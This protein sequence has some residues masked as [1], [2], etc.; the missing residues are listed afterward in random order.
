MNLRAVA[1]LT[2]AIGRGLGIGHL[3]RCRTIGEWLESR[4]WEVHSS[5]LRIEGEDLSLEGI[6]LPK[7]EPWGSVRGLW[8]IDASIMTSSLVG[9][10]LRDVYR[11]GGA[12]WRVCIIDNGT[13]SALAP[14]VS[15]AID[16]SLVVIPHGEC[17]RRSQER[18]R[19]GIGF[20]VLPM[21]LFDSAELRAL[22]V[23]MVAARLLVTAGGVDS[24]E[25]S[26]FYV[27][28]LEQINNECLHVTLIIGRDFSKKHIESLEARTQ[29]SRHAWTLVRD[30]PSIV[31]FAAETD[32]ALVA[33]GLTK[34]EMCAMGI[35][36]VIV[37][38]TEDHAGDSDLLSELGAALR[39]GLLADLDPSEC[40]KS[41][42]CLLVDSARRQAMV[43]IGRGA[44][45]RRFVEMTIAE[46]EEA[47]L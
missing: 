24:A 6:G 25:I 17:G 41:I 47:A 11:G 40:A 33:G 43:D 28:C 18:F 39:L 38:E 46:I 34:I 13:S 45:N 20:A 44:V 2:P 36:S 1:V 30:V 10:Y 31:P 22:D 9:T 27:D 16:P 7:L 19:I 5:P 15:P 42:A 4:G 26:S 12:G 32:L 8:L 37:D 35:P 21:S 29:L 3:R 23:P 14:H